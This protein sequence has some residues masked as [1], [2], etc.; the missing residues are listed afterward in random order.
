MTIPPRIA[1]PSSGATKDLS[2]SGSRTILPVEPFR[3][4]GRALLL[5]G[6]LITLT[7][8]VLYFGDHL[9]LKLGRLPGDIV[10]R[11]EHSTL[12]FPIVTCLVVSAGLTLL[13]WLVGHFRR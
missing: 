3:E 11:G 13:F 4:L 12:Y 10:Y 1:I 8:A 7:G 2:A 5:I 9:P 6:G